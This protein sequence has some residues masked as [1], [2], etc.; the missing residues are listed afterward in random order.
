MS[1]SSSNDYHHHKLI[2]HSYP[3]EAVTSANWIKYPNE[4]TSHVIHVDYLSRTVDP[5]SG[6]LTTERLL[7]CQQ[8]IPS[9][10]SRLSGGCNT[11]MIYER[12]TVDPHKRILQL[13]SRNLTFSHLMAVEEICTYRPLHE[14][15]V[16][17][18]DR[19]PRTLFQQEA[20]ISSV[21]GGAAWASFLKNA[22]EEFCVTRFQ[23][24]ALKGRAALELALER[25]YAGAKEQMLEFLDVHESS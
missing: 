14:E 8:N 15:A 17:D 2:I 16:A 9:L 24:N 5:S 12:S 22:V 4:L 20:R 25:L 23:A 1:T 10:I 7:T 3:W 19:P 21:A 11:S 6:I 18:C 13:R